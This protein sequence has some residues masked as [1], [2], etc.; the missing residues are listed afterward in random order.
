MTNT[1]KIAATVH[2]MD[3]EKE[4]DRLR[5]CWKRAKNAKDLDAMKFFERAAE[6]IKKDVA[7]AKRSARTL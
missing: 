2:I 6:D 4:I 5:G 7:Y 3:L 1:D